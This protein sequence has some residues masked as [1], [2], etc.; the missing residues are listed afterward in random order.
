[1]PRPTLGDAVTI[2]LRPERIALLTAG[3]TADNMID[4]LITDV[5]SA[6]PSLRV[7]VQTSLGAM[8]AVVASWRPGLFY[9]APGQQGR[10]GW[11]AGAGWVLP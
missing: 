11:P 3:E 5:R 8:M 7:Q 10:I 6:G 1:M 9:P 4:A 2:C